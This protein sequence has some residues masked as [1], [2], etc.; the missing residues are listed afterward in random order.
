MRCLFAC[1]FAL[2]LV[3]ALRAQPA[4]AIY[5]GGRIWTGD[6]QNPWAEALAVRAE[7]LVA[8]GRAADV[9]AFR[10]NGT[11]VV[12]LEGRFVVPGLI[13]NHV[14]FLDGGDALGSVDLRSADTPE[15][16]ARRLAAFARDRSADRWI[17]G[18]DW[19]HEAWG[20]ALPT[21]HWIDE[22]TG[23]VPVFVRRLDGHMALANSAALRLAGITRQTPDPDG[24]TIVRDADGEP[25]GVLKDNAMNLVFAAMP[26]LSEA[27]TEEAIE[28][29]TAHAAAH[30]VTQVHDMSAGGLLDTYRRLHAQGRLK[31]RIYG[32]LPLADWQTLQAYIA[33][34]GRGD[35]WVR[36]GLLKGFVDGSLGSTTAWFYT[37]FA[38]E[39]ETSG[40][41]VEDT[42]VLRQRILD[43][44]AAGLHV[45][46]HAIGDRANTWLL[47]TFAEAE[48]RNG[49]RDRRFRIEHA[50]HLT[51]D[52]I[53]AM[54]A[55]GVVPS[56]Q[57]YHAID[58]GRWAEKRIGPDRIQTTYAF[59]SLLDAG[60]R[61]TFG[62]DW[63][64]APL[65][66]LY[67]LYA[68]VTRQTLDG[69]HPEGWVPAQKVQLE[70]A[71]R[72]YTAAN[73]WA[74]FQ[75]HEAGVLAPGYLA[76]FVVLSDDLFAIAPE[77]L[78]DVAVLRTVVGGHDVFVAAPKR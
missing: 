26:P 52:A 69:A 57:P 46:V 62:S 47:R 4:D 65:D 70:E 78:R 27:E 51:P 15:E 33:Q 39:P 31:T 8:V 61:L 25:T 5:T 1:C 28:R 36:W 66:P 73:A 37:P 64:V 50:Q 29:A 45:A 35:A 2:L 42:T 13:D 20:G 44:D 7:T 48:G 76:D 10:G 18:G 40:F 21:R 16:F 53:T 74:G 19:D 14:H 32:A 75:E 54:A 63:F 49:L 71:L 3:A 56:M 23:S 6:V 30:G 43:A 77:K 72:A 12:N 41:P 22:G 58:D 24:G 68:A 11:R 59:R 67:G 38:D 60:A 34:N 17:T 9:E 55:Q